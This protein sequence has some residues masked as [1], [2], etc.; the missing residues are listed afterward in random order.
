[1]YAYPGIKQ[2]AEATPW[3][4]CG[5]SSAPSISPYAALPGHLSVHA[6]LALYPTESREV[7]S[8]N[9]SERWRSGACAYKTPD[10]G[11]GQAELLPSEG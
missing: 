3:P 10:H 7:R 8:G 5:V 4:V 2:A 1:M 11:L 6:E 9:R